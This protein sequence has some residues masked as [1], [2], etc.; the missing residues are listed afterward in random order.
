MT[1]AKYVVDRPITGD[2]PQKP[3]QSSV[4]QL[5]AA[6]FLAEIDR[7]LAA[8]GVSGLIWEQYTPYFNDGD[9]C[10]F[11]LHEVRLLI[12]GYDEEK[13]GEP[14]YGTGVSAYD[15]F[16]WRSNAPYPK[17][18]KSNW[19]EVEWY[20]FGETTGR[21]IR[22]LLQDLNTS[23]WESVAQENFGD[24]AQVTATADGFNVEFYEH[25]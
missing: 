17:H 21:E 2:E 24:H 13:H 19:D 8:P 16:S 18:D 1:D 20:D 15:T 3:F 6:E 9:P 14:E 23:G 10:E 11:S 5:T 12:D 4:E 7:V 22:A 25:D